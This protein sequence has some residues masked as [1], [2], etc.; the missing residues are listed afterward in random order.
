MARNGVLLTRLLPPRLPPDCLARPALTQRLLAGMG[1]RLVTVLGGAGYGKSTVVAQAAA[2]SPN[3]TVWVSCDERLGS[4]PD[5][6]A[7]VTSGI[8]RLMPGFG[9]SLSFEGS[10]AG[11]VAALCNEFVATSADDLVLVLDDV[12]LLDAEATEAAGGLVRD[13][14]PSVHLVLVG[15]APL[16]FPLGKLRAGQLV[17]LTERDLALD[18]DEVAALWHG[19]G[20]PDDA[21]TLARVRE[22]TEGWVTGVILAAQAGDADLERRSDSGQLFDYLAE[23]VLVAQDRDV[24]DFLLQT[25]MLERFTP[26]IAAAT[27]GSDDAGRIC[28]E[29]V[30]RHLFTIRLDAEGEWY[31]YH[32]LFQAFLRHRVVELE[33]GLA[34]E[35]H[36]RAANAWITA[37]EPVQAVDHLLAAGELEQAADLVESLADELRLGPQARLLSRWIT[38][39]PDELHKGRPALTLAH[40][41]AVFADGDPEA[42]FALID[43]CID[44]FVEAGEHARAAEGFFTL[45]YAQLA[46]GTRQHHAIDV[47]YRQLARID[48]SAKHLPGSMVLMASELGCATRYDEADR[49]LGQVLQLPMPTIDPLGPGYLASARAFYMDHPRGHSKQAL[50]TIDWVIAL[51]ERNER[52]DELVYLLAL[53]VYRA[54]LLNHLGRY[55]ETLVELDALIATALRRGITKGANRPLLKMRAVALAGLE[56]WDELEALLAADEPVDHMRGSS[57][58]FRVRAP[59]ARLAAHRGDTAAVAHHA[60][61][62]MDYVEAFGFSFDTPVWICDIAGSAHQA[63]LL[64]D[65]RRLLVHVLEGAE[66]AQSPWA[67]ARGQLLAAVVLDGDDAD[68]ALADALQLTGDWGFEEIWTRRDRA[69]AP[70]PLARAIDAEIGPPG[71][72]AILAARAGGDVLYRCAEQ[73]VTESSPGRSRLVAALDEEGIED[74]D[75]RA[76]LS[77]VSS[78][79]SRT[80]AGLPVLRPP[81]RISAMGGF[82]V[83]RG[84]D[85]IPVS[86][87]GRERA[88]AVLGVLLCAG[89]PVHREKLVDWLWPD[90][91]LERGLRALHVTLH[92]LRRAVEPE[93]GR[94]SAGRSVVRSEGEGFRLVLAEGDSTDVAEFLALARPPT[95]ETPAE[96]VRRLT[97]AER[98]YAGPVYPEW[99]YAD[100][101]NACRD[102]VERA[103]AAVLEGLADAFR[104]SG[105]P[106]EAVLRLERLVEIRPESE[107]F[108]RR[109]MLAYSEAGEKAL[110]LRQYHACRTVLRRE[111]GVEAS[112]ETRALY[113]LILDDQPVSG[114]TQLVVA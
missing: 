70:V 43:T 51:F 12:H 99:P 30:D 57:Y 80:D 34:P 55:D 39:L 76:R 68:A 28:R 41:I 54:M 26:E 9:T 1:G 75:V 4:A 108:H 49:V 8:G 24:Q 64:D 59:A 63:G 17:A 47:G 106:R 25:A 29:L 60:A 6:L 40:A 103:H 52:F 48:P 98:A 45:I 91:D 20:G 79:S 53:R 84:G 56:R 36:R 50:V 107:A 81:L 44:D 82:V 71:L 32:H 5:L 86:A 93:L 95:D 72:A 21:P 2:A 111:L 74:A 101:A 31:R 13:L 102:E 110:A 19:S 18:E 22:R 27:A 87:F 15:R 97:T 46:S 78:R 3:P 37:G 114:G 11:Q 35:L 100:W 33:P 96:T 89:G 94:G 113:R 83:R 23:E 92:G 61:V 73:L 105:R 109:L 67:R 88:R 66:R 7:H 16:S 85:A 77:S 58:G 90:L 14:P 62:V 42:G 10:V 38:A 69:L 104:S 65:A 112:A